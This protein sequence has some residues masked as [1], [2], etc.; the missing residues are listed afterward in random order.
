MELPSETVPIRSRLHYRCRLFS[1]SHSFSSSSRAR[2]SSPL[3]IFPFIVKFL[4]TPIKVCIMGTVALSKFSE[5]VHKINQW[6][7]VQTWNLSSVK[8]IY[9]NNMIFY[10]C[11]HGIYE[12]IYKWRKSVTKLDNNNITE[13]NMI[14]NLI[15]GQMSFVVFKKL[16]C[17]TYNDHRRNIYRNCFMFHSISLSIKYNYIKV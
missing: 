1:S 11:K 7:N 16:I 8:T 4:N 12:F 14:N 13:I 5:T 6:D 15:K 10:A 2:A 17:L 3:R 9:S